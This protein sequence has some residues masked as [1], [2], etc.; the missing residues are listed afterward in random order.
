MSLN[1]QS[2]MDLVE[3]VTGCPLS[4]NIFLENAPGLDINWEGDTAIIACDEPT[5]LT[6]AVF[7]LTAHQKRGETSLHL[8]QTRHFQSCGAMLDMSRNGVFTVDGAK[9]YMDA[10]AALGMNML[11]LYTEDMYEVPGYPAFGYLRGRFSQN[12]LRELDR[13]ACS[14][15]IELIPCIQSLAHLTQFLRWPSSEALRDQPNCL[16]VDSEETYK[17]IEAMISSL[18]SCFSSNRIHIGMDEAYG[19][20]L[21]H[22]LSRN[23]FQNRY[24]LLRRHLE[25]V[26]SICESHHFRPIMWSDMFF[27]LISKTGS[28]YDP[29]AEIPAD[30]HLDRVDL[31][32]WD[33]YH[34]DENMYDQMLLKHEKMCDHPVF[35]GGIWTWRGFLPNY[36]FT[37]AS[38]IPALRVCARHEVQTV[39]ATM[40]GDDGQECSH[41]LAIPLLPLFSEACWEGPDY[42]MELVQCYGALVS[43]LP[44]ELTD[45]FDLFYPEALCESGDKDMVWGDLLY[46]LM[47]LRKTTP[48]EILS[49]T[50]LA[51]EKLEHH[52]DTLEYNYTHTLFQLVHM[53]ADLAVHLRPAYLAKDFD[54]LKRCLSMLPDLSEVY[55]DMCTLHRTLWERDYRRQGWQD[56]CLRYGALRGRIDDVADELTRYLDGKLDCIP[57]LD[58]EPLPGEAYAWRYDNLIS[59]GAT[60]V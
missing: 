57:E 24:D 21:G 2:A 33:Y 37:F 32:Y 56:I 27:S 10:M 26:T 49:R 19:V 13:Y 28:Y 25:R 9:R 8:H 38:M 42:D 6:R 46:P 58:E 14:L 11:M 59:P 36:R 47:P 16:L 31:A 50:G 53:R 15:G 45:V 30:M 22:Y 29:E 55:A 48:E 18:R 52:P 41:F 44:R 5:A 4:L 34:T 35:A 17:L 60:P 20:G 39:F 7:L 12:D 43:R 23:G 3:R 40:W 1:L 54:E 51:L